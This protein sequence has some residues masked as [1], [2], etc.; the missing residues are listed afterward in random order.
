APFKIPRRIFIRDQLPKGATGKVLRL[1]LTECFEEMAS[2]EG[3]TA[4]TQSM[5]G[6]SDIDLVIQLKEIWERLLKISPVSLDDDFFV[7]GGDSL[8]AV[9]MLVELERLTGRSIPA[10]ILFDAPTIRQLTQKL[11]ERGS[12]NQRP[13]TLIRLNSR[14]SKGPLFYFP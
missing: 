9:E 10:S 13:M 7:C 6:A 1:S 3:Q 11:S 14:G 4:A 2:A 5:H 12:L 8:I